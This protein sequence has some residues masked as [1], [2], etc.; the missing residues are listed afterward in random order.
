MKIRTSIITGFLCIVVLTVTILVY[1]ILIDI[2]LHYLKSMEESLVDTAILLAGLVQEDLH[3]EDASLTQLRS[4]FQQAYERKFSAK[5]YDLQKTGLNLHVYITDNSGTV[6]FDSEN[7]NNEGRDYS[8]M[9]DVYLTLKGHYGARAT[10]ID[11]NNPDS[12]ILYVA[13]PIYDGDAI[14]GVLSVSKPARSV[15]PFVQLARNK[16]I[17]GGI[18]AAGAAIFLGFFL[19]MW[20]TRS[21]EQLTNYAHSVRDGKK[22]ALPYLSQ[23]EIKTL[24][25]AFEEMRRALEGKNYVE[26]YVQSLTHELKSPISAIRGAAELISE[27]MPDDK[28]NYFI[29]NIKNESQRMGLLIERLLQLAALESKQKL[30]QLTSISLR[31][32]IEETVA[33]FAVVSEQKNVTIDINVSETILLEGDSFLLRQAFDN[34]IR[35]S[36][37][38]NPQGTK[39]EISAEADNDQ[40]VLHFNDEGPGIPEFALPRVFERFYSLTDAEKRKKSS[41]LG[42]NI[43]HEIIILHQGSIALSNRPESGLEVLI[44]LPTRLS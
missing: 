25:E 3:H 22:T 23:S 9:N 35:N 29:E 41:G 42:L 43:V 2:R 31:P 10:R 32:L 38:H 37:H 27:E 30:D 36:L 24:G 7:K 5:I 44:T 6:I 4:A 26:H 28:R 40:I 21:V 33:S 34:L 17:F 12:S 15:A 11:K 20:V 1:W 14:I 16:V 13:A 18:I 39:I 8:Q 19:T